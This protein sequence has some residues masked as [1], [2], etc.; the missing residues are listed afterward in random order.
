MNRWI[1]Q[2][3]DTLQDCA[4]YLEYDLM[5]G[6]CSDHEEARR[7]LNAISELVDIRATRSPVRD[8]R[9]AVIMGDDR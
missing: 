5:V 2:T 7:I 3:Q 9:Q 1:E 4:K 8:T 6:N